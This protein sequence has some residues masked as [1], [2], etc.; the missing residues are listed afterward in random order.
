[1]EIECVH[2]AAEQPQLEKS[3]QSILDQDTPFVNIQF[4]NEVPLQKAYYVAFANAKNDWILVCAGDM[5]YDLDMHSRIK[6]RI[7]EEMPYIVIDQVYDFQF[8]MYDPFIKK[9]VKGVQVRNRNLVRSN[10]FQDRIGSDSSHINTMRR[11]G[12][13]HI[14]FHTT[15]SLYSLLNDRQEVEA[16]TYGT[17]FENPSEFQVFS[18]FSVVGAKSG[19]GSRRGKAPKQYSTM[20]RLRKLYQNTKDPL[21]VLA[22]DAYTFGREN[23][24]YYDHS[25]DLDLSKRMWALFQET[26]GEQKC[27]S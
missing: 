18:R 25:I 20:G 13:S 15:S 6:Q 8:C 9:V 11:K 17:H 21:Y 23:H 10:F 7:A 27:D 14:K 12:F 5:I 2:F 16:F 24:A 22:M 4:I 3:K 1:M 26:R 19:R